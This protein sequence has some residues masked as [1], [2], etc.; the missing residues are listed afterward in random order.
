MASRCHNCL[1]SEESD[2]HLFFSYNLANAL[3]SWLLPPYG[4]IL[5]APTSAAA[6]WD[7]IS[8]GGDA[9]GSHLAAAIFFHAIFILWLLRNDSKHNGQK[10]YKKK[11]QQRPKVSATALFGR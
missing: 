3:W 2:S 10:H 9:S 1:L 7:A 8:L 6:I 11:A 5:P 4:Y